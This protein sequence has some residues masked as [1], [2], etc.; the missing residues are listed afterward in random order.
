MYSIQGQW[1]GKTNGGKCPINILGE[2]S[3]VF[4]GKDIK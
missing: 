1:Q 4:D 2:K 3:I